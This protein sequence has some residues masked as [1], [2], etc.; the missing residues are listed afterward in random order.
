LYGGHCTG[1]DLDPGERRNL[2]R[3]AAAA[4]A[5]YGHVAATELRDQL[6]KVEAENAQLRGMERKLTE[7][8]AKRP[9]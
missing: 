6:A 4:A 5:G 8:L 7:L 1:E 9:S 3:L 2:R